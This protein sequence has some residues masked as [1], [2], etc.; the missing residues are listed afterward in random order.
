[1]PQ[2]NVNRRVEVQIEVGAPTRWKK[3]GDYAVEVDENQED[4]NQE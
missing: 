4:K 1:M 3:Y 2:S